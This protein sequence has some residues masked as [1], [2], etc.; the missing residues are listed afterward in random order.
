V[1][2]SI[3]IKKTFVAKEAE[4]RK[5]V[6]GHALKL[7]SWLIPVKQATKQAIADATQQGQDRVLL[8]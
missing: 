5:G 1:S 3:T 4:I 8:V 6:L 7:G 2:G